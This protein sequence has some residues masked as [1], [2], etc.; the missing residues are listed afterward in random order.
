VIDRTIPARP[1]P[2]FLSQQEKDFKFQPAINSL[3]G[4]RDTITR[5]S[6]E[7]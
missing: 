3:G 7:N 5:I 6:F 1:L 4:F 2:D